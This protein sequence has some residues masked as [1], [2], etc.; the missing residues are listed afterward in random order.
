MVNLL[1]S[2]QPLRKARSSTDE[3]DAKD[4]CTGSIR[5]PARCAALWL[6]LA[7]SSLDCH[8]TG[9]ARAHSGTI[10]AI[11]FLRRSFGVALRAALHSLVHELLVPRWAEVGARR[12]GMSSLRVAP[13]AADEVY[14]VN[15][16]DSSG[17]HPASEFRKDI[18]DFWQHERVS[19]SGQL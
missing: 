2:F 13:A 3:V 11:F 12:G 5:P 17:V 15:E 4:R 16:V 7:Q 8:A 14:W 19:E 10:R 9:A 6:L 1:D 18:C